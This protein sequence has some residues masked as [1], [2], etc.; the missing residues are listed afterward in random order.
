MK[1]IYFGFSAKASDGQAQFLK[2][3]IPE[4]VNI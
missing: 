2:Q 4:V 3:Y 1:K